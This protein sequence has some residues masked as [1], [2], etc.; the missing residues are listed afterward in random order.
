[1]RKVI[2]FILAIAMLVVGLYILA[3]QF[4]WSPYIWGR[5]VM[6]GA[7]LTTLGVALLWAAFIEP[8]LGNKERR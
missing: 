4:L 7:F 2:A 3:G 1:M 8:I 6:M 5:L